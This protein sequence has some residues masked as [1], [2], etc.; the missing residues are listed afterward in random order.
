V[1]SVDRARI[2]LRLGEY[3]TAPAVALADGGLLPRVQEYRR[4][5]GSRITA[6]GRDEIRGRIPTGPTHV[7]R[8]MD[9]EFT[10][11][12]VEGDE[13]FT[14]NPGG[15]VRVGLPFLAEAQRLVAASGRARAL[16]CGELY[17][18]RPDGARTRIH[19][20]MGITARP[21]SRAELESLRFAAFDLLDPLPTYGETYAEL[22][23]MF[24]EGKRIHPVET[25]LVQAPAEI[26]ELFRRWV[27]EEGFEGIVA[28]TP[29][30]GTFKVKT[31]HSLD[32]V[33]VGFTEGVDDR[34]GMIHDLL[35]ALMRKD[36][37]F[38]LLARVGGGF[39]EE[40][41]RGFLAD[42]RD[43]SADSEYTE[44]N[45][46]HLAYQMVRPEWVI[47]ISC[48]DVVAQTTRGG[49]IERMVLSWDGNAG[50]YGVVRRLP[51]ATLISPNF[52][53]RRPDKS[54]RPEDLRLEQL[55]DIVDIP[56]VDKQAATMTLQRSEI[57]RREVYVKTLKG[58]K[59]VRKLVL[60]KTN[61]DQDGPWPAFV[62]AVTDFSP[63]RATPLER[64][65]RVSSSR[66][67]IEELWAELKAAY[68]VGGWKAA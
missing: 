12:V 45:P 52:V 55:A 40:A 6:L 61:K 24:G 17:V 39:T 56:L 46:D 59:M 34:K 41:R 49:P 31:K 32:V 57:L 62:V 18:V 15:T 51:L 7:S 48:V 63:N 30:A 2:E 47:E 50:R 20:V 27:E 21:Q 5:V 36:G 14:L 35:V 16:V 19:D 42:L 10:V 67:Q 25:K 9:G 68:V 44:V 58:K 53:Q 29:A 65:L 43:L 37:T 4:L 66:E 33:V 11:L 54:V 8:K 1:K 64:D 38:Q 13:A 22:V 28:R 60:W 23:R 26:E 3:G